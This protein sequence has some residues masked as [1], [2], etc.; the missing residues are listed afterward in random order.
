MELD[1]LDI[2]GSIR[3]LGMSAM[4]GCLQNFFFKMPSKDFFIFSQ[5][6][7]NQ[8]KGKKKKKRKILVYEIK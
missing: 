4:T 7:Q 3:F 6:L 2:V 1:G 5:V 8:L